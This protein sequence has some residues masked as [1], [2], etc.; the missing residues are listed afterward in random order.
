MT[1]IINREF[2]DKAMSEAF[3]LPDADLKRHASV[4]LDN[5]HFCN[6]CFCCAC[7]VTLAEREGRK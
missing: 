4:S 7:V 3:R 6:D 5:R 2:W 1:D